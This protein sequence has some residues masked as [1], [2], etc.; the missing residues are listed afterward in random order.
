MTTGPENKIKFS[1]LEKP[2]TRAMIVIRLTLSILAVITFYSL[3]TLDYGSVNIPRAVCDTLNNFRTIFIHPFS[4]RLSIPDIF[5]EILVT[6][7]LSILI[8]VFSGV[9]ALFLGLL[10]AR[11]LSPKRV[12]SA[13][14]AFVAFIRAVPSIL[15]V[16]IFA[17]SA[18]LG[19]TAAVI[20][21]SFHSIGYLTKAFAECYEELDRGVIDALKSTGAGW[22][23]I[24]FQ[25]VIP[26]SATYLLSWTFLRFELNFSNAVAM[27]AAAGAAGIGF[28][29]FMS[30]TMY[31]DLHE[32][33]LITYFILAFAV[34]LEIIAM[35][36][37]SKL[38]EK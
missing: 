24:V 6:I 12:T 27:G 31:F 26:S 19:S 18:G 17:V 7:G 28:D 30:S 20:G 23:T 3:I 36:V 15:W 9:I 2:V 37:K 4:R 34:T 38:K 5:Y 11:N 25:A 1:G 8:T 32:V 35:K 21:L 16:L 29:L 10:G 22:W 14:K 33:G 13:V